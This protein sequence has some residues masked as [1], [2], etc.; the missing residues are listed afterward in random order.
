M[1][2]DGEIEHIAISTDGKRV[3]SCTGSRA[4]AVWEVETGVTKAEGPD[5]DW[6]VDRVAISRDGKI[7]ACVSI[8][9]CVL[10]WNVDNDAMVGGP[11]QLGVDGIVPSLTFSR[12]NKRLLSCT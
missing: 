7:V 9:G 1:R 3:V 10:L 6:S 2:H 8:N 11:L 5:G 4:S 12:D